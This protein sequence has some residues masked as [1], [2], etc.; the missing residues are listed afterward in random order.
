MKRMAAFFLAFCLFTVATLSACAEDAERS[1]S[2]VLAVEICE[3]LGSRAA[4]CGAEERREA[5]KRMAMTLPIPC[6]VLTPTACQKS[7][8]NVAIKA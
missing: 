8:G 2:G 7:G 1:D 3:I 4:W 5:M 6:L